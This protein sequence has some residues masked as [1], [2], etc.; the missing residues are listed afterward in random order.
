[1]PSSSGWVGPAHSGEGAGRGRPQGHR[2]RARRHAHAVGRLRAAEH[3]DELRYVARH[4]LMMNT[5]RDTLT[6]RNNPAQEALPMRRLGS[7]L[8]AT[9]WRLG[10]PLERPHLALD[11]HGI[12]GALAL[13][14][15]LRQDVNPADMTIQDWGIT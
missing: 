8:P 3:R 2:P 15:A 6:I 4:D 7:F 1:M 5:A 13:R 11:R 10:R 12:Q 14:G 9:A